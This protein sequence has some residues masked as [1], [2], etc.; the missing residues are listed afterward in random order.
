VFPSHHYAS[1]DDRGRM[2]VQEDK[3]WNEPYTPNIDQVI[4]NVAD[5]YQDRMGII[6]F[7]GMCD[8]GAVTSIDLKDQGVPLWAQN[9]EDCIC[10]A[11]PEA[12][13]KKNAVNYIGT[14]E[15]LA[16]HLNNR[17]GKVNTNGK[18]KSSKGNDN[19]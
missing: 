7:S 16:K 14:A 1:V 11:M 4:R 12:V 15:E 8:D 18:V 3:R 9:P 13:I 2:W 5:Y 17:Y 19:V 10:S 6:I